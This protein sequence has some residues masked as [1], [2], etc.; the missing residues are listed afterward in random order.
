[1]GTLQA[2]E[3]GTWCFGACRKSRLSCEDADLVVAG[4]YVGHR[5]WSLRCAWR[6]LAW[7]LLCSLISELGLHSG[8][9]VRCLLD[10]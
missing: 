5:Y 8:S 3:P 1:M 7:D 2:C 10:S 9:F 4:S 6:K